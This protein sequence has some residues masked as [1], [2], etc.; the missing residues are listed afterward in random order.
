MAFFP[1]QA[2]DDVNDQ[3]ALFFPWCVFFSCADF[4]ALGEHDSCFHPRRE[5]AF[6][7][8]ALGIEF[9]IALM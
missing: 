8:M 3:A 9:H 5:L 6:Y 7:V 2:H 1:R 4:S